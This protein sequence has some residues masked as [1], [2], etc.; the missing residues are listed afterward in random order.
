[1]EANLV[2]IS[3]KSYQDLMAAMFRLAPVG[4]TSI[5]FFC[6]HSVLLGDGNQH[7]L[8]SLRQDLTNGPNGC[9]LDA[10]RPSCSF[11]GLRTCWLL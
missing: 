10:I 6:I 1:M 8:R 3:C 4:R 7:C 5:L 2:G 9:L 11:P